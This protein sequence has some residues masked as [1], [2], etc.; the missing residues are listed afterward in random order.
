MLL[1]NSAKDINWAIALEISANG[2]KYDVSKWIQS[3]AIPD[4][5]LMPIEIGFGSG[6]VKVA[7]DSPSYSPLSVQF[8]VDE[9]WEILS[10]LYSNLFSGSRASDPQSIFGSCTLFAMDTYRIPKFKIEFMNIVP[11]S[12]S[13]INLQTTM[14]TTPIMTQVQFDF[15]QLIFR[16]LGTDGEYGLG[17]GLKTTGLYRADGTNTASAYQNDAAYKKY[18]VMLMQ[19]DAQHIPWTIEL[20]G[21]DDYTVLYSSDEVPSFATANQNEPFENSSKP[22]ISG[23]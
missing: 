12:V 3:F 6:R 10:L 7:G 5:N 19:A 11:S 15:S 13:S 4:I 8:L 9:N 18:Q 20:L 2:R 23:N 17:A 16:K 1:I 14:N 22:I 21:D